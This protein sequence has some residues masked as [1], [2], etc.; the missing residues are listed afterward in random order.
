M[1]VDYEWNLY[2]RIILI[3]LPL[4]LLSLITNLKHLVPFSTLAN[5][6][7]GTGFGLTLYYIFQD[8]PDIRELRYTGELSKLPLC[9]GSAIY[10]F[11]GIALVLP[12]KNIMKNPR[13]FD[14]PLGVLNIGMI[15]IAIIFTSFGLLG[16]WRWGD[17]VK[18][19][20]TLNLP[21]EE[22]YLSI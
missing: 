18:D 13:G 12:L 3:L 10:A 21:E 14:R 5:L 16:Y 20:M 22:M 19:S 1:Y 17:K 7:M 15:F 6:F 2:I 4:L 11:E 9:I 8:L